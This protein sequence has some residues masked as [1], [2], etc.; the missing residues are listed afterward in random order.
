MP[1]D[2][3]A[4]GVAGEWS[5]IAVSEH[6]GMVVV[7]ESAGEHLLGVGGE[8]DCSVLATFADAAAV[9]AGARGEVGRANADEFGHA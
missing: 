4:D 8:R 5:A 6:D 1:V 7:I 2:D 9:S 3:A